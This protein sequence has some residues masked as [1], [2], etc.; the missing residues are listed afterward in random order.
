MLLITFQNPKSKSEI[1]RAREESMKSPIVQKKQ[2][3]SSREVQS[4]RTGS[5]TLE[6]LPHFI[7][8]QHFRHNCFI[9]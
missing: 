9:E 7:E 1:V 5:A 8:S 4:G 2:I 3:I 6:N